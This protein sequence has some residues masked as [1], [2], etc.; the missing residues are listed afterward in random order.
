MDCR[1]RIERPAGIVNRVHVTINGRLIALGDPRGH[2][3]EVV[4]ALA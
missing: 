4:A 3:S 2:R 1:E